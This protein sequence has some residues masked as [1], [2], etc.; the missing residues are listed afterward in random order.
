[1][2]DKK[3]EKSHGL[4]LKIGFWTMLALF[5]IMIIVSIFKW[6][7]PSLIAGALFMV[8]V[9]YVFVMSIKTLAPEGKSM[10]YIALGIAILFIIYILLSLTLGLS[11]SGATSGVVG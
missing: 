11:A 1:M 4:C 7:W 3:I 8:S 10:A 2:A 6:Q 5:L 9:L